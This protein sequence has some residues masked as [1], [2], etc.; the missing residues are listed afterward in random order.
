MMNHENCHELPLVIAK[1][2]P[3]KLLCGMAQ[4]FDVL[5]NRADVQDNGEPFSA[6]RVRPL[7]VALVLITV[8]W[9]LSKTRVTGG[10]LAVHKERVIKTARLSMGE[11]CHL[12][13]Y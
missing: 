1:M 7:A 4:G 9:Q 8:C 2:L 3:R 5:L 11:T 13:G 6:Y 12:N 10:I